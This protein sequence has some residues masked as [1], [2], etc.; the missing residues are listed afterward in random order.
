MDN[1]TSYRICSGGDKYFIKGFFETHENKSGYWEALNAEGSIPRNFPDCKQYYKTLEEAY[2]AIQ[3]FEN[4]NPNFEHNVK[5][6]VIQSFRIFPLSPTVYTVQVKM[7]DDHNWY[8]TN[9]NGFITKKASNTKLYDSFDEAEQAMRKFDVEQI[10][11]D[12]KVKKIQYFTV[13]AYELINSKLESISKV[14]SIKE[15]RNT[16]DAF[17]NCRFTCKKTLVDAI[18]IPV[19]FNSPIAM[20]FK[21]I[22]LRISIVWHP[23]SQDIEIVFT[24]MYTFWNKESIEHQSKFTIEGLK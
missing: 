13:S 20:E 3:D 1:I 5:P 4:Y 6:E 9:G 23:V 12:Q 16:I 24:Y 19:D 22:K 2:N 7:K 14:V 11:A 8:A 10:L 15:I 18:N 17:A 21:S